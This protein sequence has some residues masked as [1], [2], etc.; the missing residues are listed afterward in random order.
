MTR[1]PRRLLLSGLLAAPAI[2]TARAQS[3]PTRPVS[4]V[5]PFAPGG[6]SDIVGR[7]IARG[8]QTQLGQPVVVENVAGAGGSIGTLRVAR[9]APDGYTLTLGH[10]GTLAANVPLYPNLGYDPRRDFAPIGLV[11]RNPAMLGVSLRS[12]VTDLRGFIEFVRA[13]NGDATFGTAGVGSQTH[14]AAALFL[15]LTGLRATI[16]AYRGSGPAVQDLAAGTVDAVMEQT[17]TLIPAHRSGIIRALAVT[18]PQR[19]T[20]TPDV[21]TFAEAGLP[22]FDAGNWQALAAPRGTPE[23]VIARLTAALI[24]AQ[25]DPEVR[26]RFADLAAEVPQAA[27]RGPAYL[28]RHIDTEVT[29]WIRI[30]READ[31]RLD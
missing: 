12:G 25:D 21:P 4:I 27:D 29:R 18:T 20:Q 8:L 10:I 17:L 6:A 3:F 7:I 28:A 15:N 26:Q 11:V 13:R 5:V 9:A 16:V 2:G 1:F 23:P 19:I 30:V 14:L 24:A 31:I 22:A